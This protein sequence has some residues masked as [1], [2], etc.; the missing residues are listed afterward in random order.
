MSLQEDLLTVSPLGPSGNE[1]APAKNFAG[2]ISQGSG[3]T[4]LVCTAAE[5]KFVVAY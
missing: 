4:S 3:I 5:V 1:F 2:Q